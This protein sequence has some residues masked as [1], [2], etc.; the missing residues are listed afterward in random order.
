MSNQRTRE[1]VSK[2][3][4]RNFLAKEVLDRKGP[5]KPK[6]INPKKAYDRNKERVLDDY[7]E[8]DI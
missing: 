4:K 6:V 3:R 7:Y 8:E 5:F 1:R 2:K